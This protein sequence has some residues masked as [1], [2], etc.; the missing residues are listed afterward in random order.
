MG[1]V[2]A[3]P[4]THIRGFGSPAAPRRRPS[5]RDAFCRTSKGP[6]PPTAP[7]H[8]RSAASGQSAAGRRTRA[9]RH[10]R[11]AWSGPPRRTAPC[12]ALHAPQC[13]LA[14][15]PPRKI[16]SPSDSV[17][18]GRHSE[19]TAR[20]SPLVLPAPAP[21]SPPDRQRQRGTARRPGRGGPAAEVDRLLE[22]RTVEL[23]RRDRDVSE[24]RRAVPDLLQH[25]LP[26]TLTHSTC[27][28]PARPPARRPPA[29][30]HVRSQRAPLTLARG[31]PSMLR[32]RRALRRH[33]QS[34]PTHARTQ[35]GAGGTG[36]SVATKTLPM[37]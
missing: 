28:A 9:R 10:S 32:S 31:L 17:M 30:P 35:A 26:H 23:V 37:P 1:R 5:Y 4:L 36:L 20:P 2:P 19:P 12:D 21:V 34:A 29:R 25:A 15:P 24:R 11:E 14:T 7:A 16:L 27:R 8:P 6:P 22:G 18:A 3:P 13:S 33:P